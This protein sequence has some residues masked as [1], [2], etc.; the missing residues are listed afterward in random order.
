MTLPRSLRN[1]LTDVILDAFHDSLARRGLEALALVCADPRAPAGIDDLPAPLRDCFEE[2]GDG[3]QLGNGW[4]VYAGDLRDRACRGWRA[5][6]DRPLEPP[7]PSLD[8]VLGAAAALFDAGLYYEAHEWL[9][10]Y[11]RDADGDDREGLQ[12]LIQVAV[13]FEHLARDNVPGARS[14]LSQGSARMMGR[15]L[16]GL[17]LDSFARAANACLD[18][19]VASG[20]AA[21]QEF[22]W[23]MVPRFPTYPAPTVRPGESRSP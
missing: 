15:R 7:D 18:R 9:E 22:D 20:A 6:G 10:R 23:T 14:L 3:L 19:I 4:S 1:R 11:W 21:P 16:R 2:R 5:V 12:G 17:D 8:V 13:A